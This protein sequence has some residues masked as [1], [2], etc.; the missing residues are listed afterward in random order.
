M[1]LS[2]PLGQ[3]DP[4]EPLY[5][6]TCHLDAMG[7]LEPELGRLASTYARLGTHPLGRPGPHVAAR[8]WEYAM[9]L[10]AARETV[11]TVWFDD[12]EAGV[13]VLEIGPGG[14]RSPL[15]PTLVRAGCE[16]ICLDT[17]TEAVEEVMVQTHYLGLEGRMSAVEADI[18]DHAYLGEN[19]LTYSTLD[20]PLHDLVVSVSVI[21]HIPRDQDA[22]RNMVG[23]LRPGG[24]LA[25]T[26]DLAVPGGVTHTS[27]QERLYQVADVW[28]RIQFLETVG[29]DPIGPVDYGRAVP[30]V[31]DAYTFGCFVG[32]KRMAS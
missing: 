23:W 28:E 21:E 18:C 32:R 9:M 11:G 2:E 29:V 25:F 4:V 13:N 5:C 16:L 17:R 20:I 6:T 30:N 10:R 14:F 31:Y 22:L 26:F 27:R 19:G 3:R 24:V 8:W 1:G 7:W 15:A 12:E